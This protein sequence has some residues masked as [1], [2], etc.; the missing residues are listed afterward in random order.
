[1]Y[2]MGGMVTQ[3][4]LMANQPGSYPGENT[5]FNGRGFHQQKFTA[6]A[7]TEADFKKW[8]ARARSSNLP[9]D[10]RTAEVL[11][12]RSTMEEFR[13]ALG[14]RDSAASAASAATQAAASLPTSKGPVLFSAIPDNFFH[15]LVTRTMQGTAQQP[16]TQG[17]SGLGL[18]PPATAAEISPEKG[19]NFA[20]AITSK[21]N[22]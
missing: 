10:S 16:L 8:V 2:M 13:S 3:L 6:S 15:S 1:M 4:N 14:E 20:A 7:M 11:A 17:Q 9:L 22:P 19:P 5:M 21:A 12:Q 18:T